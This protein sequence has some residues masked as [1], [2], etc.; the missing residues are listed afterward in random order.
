MHVGSPDT[1][2]MSNQNLTPTGVWCDASLPPMPSGNSSLPQT[3]PRNKAV[4]GASSIHSTPGRRLIP[5]DSSDMMSPFGGGS[6]PPVPSG[7]PLLLR[8]P[9]RRKAASGSSSTHSTPGKRS[10]DDASVSSSRKR[11]ALSG[12][13]SPSVALSGMNLSSSRPSQSVLPPPTGVPDL[14]R[15]AALLG[16]TGMLLYLLPPG[17]ISY[18]LDHEHSQA[19]SSSNS[20]LQPEKSDDRAES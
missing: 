11:S 2:L 20:S 9:P 12:P 3:P 14:D 8:T 7:D 15:P 10:N 5:C 18:R 19:N 17:A 6:L 16:E 13:S 4:S 1:S